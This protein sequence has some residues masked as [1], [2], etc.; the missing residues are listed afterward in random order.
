[1]RKERTIRY[2]LFTI[3]IVLISCGVVFLFT[4]SFVAAAICLTIGVIIGFLA[5]VPY[6]FLKKEDNDEDFE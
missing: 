2:T 5:F 6:P 4:K 3:G 1:M